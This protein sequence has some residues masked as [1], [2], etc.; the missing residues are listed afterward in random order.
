MLFFQKTFEKTL[1]SC[2]LKQFLRKLYRSVLSNNFF[3]ENFTVMSFQKTFEETLTTQQKKIHICRR[4]VH[5]SIFLRCYFT[6]NMTSKLFF[7][8]RQV[9]LWCCAGATRAPGE[10]RGFIDRQS[11][12]CHSSYNQENIQHFCRGEPAKDIL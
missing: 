11:Q 10:Y 5:T 7:R 8:W 9:V 1:P 2:P 12:G 6:Q 3:K 4:K